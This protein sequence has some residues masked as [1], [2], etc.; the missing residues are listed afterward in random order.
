MEDQTILDIAKMKK[1]MPQYSD[2]LI[3]LDQIFLT[4]TQ[5][6]EEIQNDQD[7]RESDA[8]Q[9]TYLYKKFHQMLYS[10]GPIKTDRFSPM[11]D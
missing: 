4:L 10:G 2:E 6:G 5:V 3:D 7:G 11:I 8:T 9:S 1:M